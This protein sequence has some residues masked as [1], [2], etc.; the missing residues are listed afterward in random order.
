[1]AEVD[2][3]A[4]GQKACDEA[5]WAAFEAAIARGDDRRSAMASY[6]ADLREC[7]L[8]RQRCEWIR[9]HLY[10]EKII[11]WIDEQK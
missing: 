5:A 2:D 1:V 6:Q 8:R 11:A 7:E 4:V 10:F 3:C 9:E